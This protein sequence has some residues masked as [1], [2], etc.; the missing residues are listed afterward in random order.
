MRNRLTTLKTKSSLVYMEAGVALCSP[1]RPTKPGLKLDTYPSKIYEPYLLTQE[2][3]VCPVRSD[4]FILIV[5]QTYWN[6]PYFFSPGTLALGRNQHFQ[7]C[8]S[9]RSWR[10]VDILFQLD[11]ALKVYWNRC[12]N[13]VKRFQYLLLR[14]PSLAAIVIEKNKA[15]WEKQNLLHSP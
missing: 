2:D 7:Q 9:C 11:Q 12:L 1:N 4:F 5:L 15:V 3:P 6:K 8:G 10:A 13:L 14:W